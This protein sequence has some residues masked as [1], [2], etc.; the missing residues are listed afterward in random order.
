[1]PNNG[2]GEVAVDQYHRYKVNFILNVHVFKLNLL[3]LLVCFCI[4]K[5]LRFFS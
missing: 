5:N 3:F 2:T 4:I 1:M